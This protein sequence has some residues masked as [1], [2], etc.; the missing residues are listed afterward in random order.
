MTKN[1]LTFEYLM[2]MSLLVMNT[3]PQGLK[4]LAF[5]VLWVLLSVAYSRCYKEAI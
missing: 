5:V 3:S 2:I 1:M 4:P